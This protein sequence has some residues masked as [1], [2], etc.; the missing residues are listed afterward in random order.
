MSD[1]VKNSE[2]H[3][4]RCNSMWYIDLGLTLKV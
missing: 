4:I 1:Q 2:L 3:I